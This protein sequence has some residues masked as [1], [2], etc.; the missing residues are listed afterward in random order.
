MPKIHAHNLLTGQVGSVIFNA[1]VGETDDERMLAYFAENADK[2]TIDGNE[3][4]DIEALRQEAEAAAKAAA[5]DEPDEPQGEPDDQPDD[6][7]VNL[8]DLT[9]EQV[10]EAY[11]T[12]IP[13][14]Q[15]T[16]R[17]GKQKA[18]AQLAAE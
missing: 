16:T 4:A 5:D 11:A 7:P 3:P 12:N 17:K 9:D 14:G 6:Q 8:D 13:D 15:A 18:L 1:G 10:A 2:Y